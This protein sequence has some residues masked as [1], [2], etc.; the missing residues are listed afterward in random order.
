MPIATAHQNLR[1]ISLA[2][3]TIHVTAQEAALDEG[4]QS[5]LA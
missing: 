3:T 1:H 5:V 4:N 2:K